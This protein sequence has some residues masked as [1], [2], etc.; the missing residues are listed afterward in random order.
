MFYTPPTKSDWKSETAITHSYDTNSGFTSNSNSDLESQD[1]TIDTQDTKDAESEYSAI[2]YHDNLEAI[3]KHLGST[4]KNCDNTSTIQDDSSSYIESFEI[5]TESDLPVPLL[6]VYEKCLKE[7]KEPKFER[8]LAS[9]EIAELFQ[10]FYR[11][12][13]LECKNY[14]TN[15]GKYEMKEMNQD[16]EYQYYRLNLTFERLLCDKFYNQIVFPL[17]GIPIDEFEKDF[18]D[19]FSDK[20]G[21][22]SYLDI[23]FRNLDIELDPGLENKFLQLLEEKILP[24][25]ELFSAERSPT[26][27]MKY[28]IK[29]HKKLSQILSDITEGKGN[30]L[31][32]DM[33]LPI[34][35]FSMIKLKELRAYFLVSQMIII[36]RFA[37][38][39]IFDNS[40]EKLQIEKGKLLYVFANFEAAI[41]YISSVT[42]ENLGIPVPSPHWDL[43]PGSLKSRGELLTLLSVPLNL[44]SLEKKVLEFKEK[45]PLIIGA[46]PTNENQNQSLFA[47]P[48]NAWLEYPKV[49]ITDQNIK[50]ISDSIDAGLR[51]L[52]G[53]VSWLSSSNLDVTGREA[54]TVE[55]KSNQ[56]KKT[57]LSETLLKQ[58]QEND[59]Y[60]AK[61]D[62][63]KNDAE[64]ITS[65]T[66]I[67]DAPKAKYNIGMGGIRVSA[68]PTGD[69]NSMLTATSSSSL[70]KLNDFSK[71]NTTSS[72]NLERSFSAGNITPLSP[73]SNKPLNR[74]NAI[75]RSRATSF[76][77]STIFSVNSASGDPSTNISNSPT[78]EHLSS[79]FSSLE[80]ALDNVRNRSRGNSSATTGM[81]SVYP[82]NSNLNSI[83]GDANTAN[84]IK[85]LENLLQ[86]LKTPF[87]AMTIEDLQ[88]MYAT[89]QTAANVL[90]SS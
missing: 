31:N 63:K 53:R 40:I 17:K 89:Y 76:I 22:L 8:S 11:T 9:F 42:L 34:L 50:S 37:N 38:E 24:E 4:N 77:N 1:V 57:L 82:N 51:N 85:S 49:G 45:N 16:S 27:K 41:S 72:Q 54:P 71:E 67:K 61:I 52:V 13:Q 3:D 81:N 12:F 79:I 35:I 15:D 70:N 55:E 90:H 7:L 23:H 59:A 69:S 47:N 21:C 2:E 10:S 28:L 48:L 58:I 73:A 66:N 64:L 32:T 46:S 44:D 14:L 6:K 20:L 43:L 26:L 86:P 36:K 83:G 87:E 80:N 88:N 39:F 33:Y 84:T 56:D 65:Q 62:V 75:I 29:I 68:K 25:F 5:P 74:A 18:N 19:E 78:K 60:I 30:I